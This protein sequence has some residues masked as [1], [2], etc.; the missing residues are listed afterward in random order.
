MR[1]GILGTGHMGSVHAR[2]YHHMPGV[3][4]GYRDTNPE[5]AD[6]FKARFDAEPCPSAG[7]LIAWADIVDICLPTDLHVDY[8][9]RAIAAGKAV[10]LE[11]PIGSTL[12]EARRVVEAAEVAGTPLM[13]G[14]VARFFPEYET[15]KKLVEQG[16]V[17]TPAAARM[18]RGGGPPKGNADWFMDHAR[19]GGVLLD[20]AI[21]D[22]DWLR[23]TLGEVKHLYSRSVGAQS[24]HGPDYALT[25]LTFENGAVGHVESTWMDPSGF[26]TAFEVAGSDGLIEFDSR[27][28]ATVRTMTAEGSRLESP[29]APTDDPYYRELESFIVA[30][31]EGKPPAVSGRDGIAAL[32]LSLAALESART[33]R[34]VVPE[35]A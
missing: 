16:A 9:M 11:K 3:T 34:V 31:R 21:H 25:T 18:R 5:R 35:K 28:E 23:W 32:A 17:G 12:E 26:R 1:V 30:V 24:G 14:Q 29:L 20:L 10:F 6:S 27:Q 8:A 13:V 2:Q 33:G 7:D 19:S 22:F 15:G 4:L